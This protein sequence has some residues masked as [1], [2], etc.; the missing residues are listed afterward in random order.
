MK[1]IATFIKIAKI[2][3]FF[4]C[5]IKIQSGTDFKECSDV[6][7]R[8]QVF[9]WLTIEVLLFYINLMSLS[10]FIFINIFKKYRSIRDR[11]GL[12]GKSRKNTDFL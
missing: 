5:M 10:M 6:V 2:I 8:S 9:A 12:A 3:I 11:E 1:V 7:G 4:I